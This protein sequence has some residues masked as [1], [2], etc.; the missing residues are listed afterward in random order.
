MTSRA[1]KR[2]RAADATRAP[3]TPQRA[4]TGPYVARAGS[5]GA[6]LTNEDALRVLVEDLGGPPERGALYRV[7]IV[8]GADGA[9]RQFIGEYLGLVK[10]RG[11]DESGRTVVDE[12][13][14]A[15]AVRNPV[16]P[17]DAPNGT[18]EHPFIIWPL[19]LWHL[20]PAEPGDLER[21]MT[22]VTEGSGEMPPPGRPPI[23]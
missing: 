10:D 16:L 1:A 23:Q 18:R 3:M 8:Q 9:H 5:W 11:L 7:G 17:A 4:M 12:I 22:Y 2:K 19:D 20:S 15:F 13:A 21:P 6:G 14:F